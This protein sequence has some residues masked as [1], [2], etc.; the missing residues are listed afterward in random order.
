MMDHLSF[1][2]NWRKS[3]LSWRVLVE[4]F[5]MIS[6][7]DLKVSESDIV[8]ISSLICLF[9]SMLRLRTKYIY[10]LHSKISCEDHSKNPI[11]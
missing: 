5:L 9:L 4:V 11:K 1:V 3:I 8:V 6:L 10:K 7:L 2:V